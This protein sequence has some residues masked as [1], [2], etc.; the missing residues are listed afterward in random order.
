MSRLRPYSLSIVLALAAGAAFAQSL[1]EPSFPSSLSAED[2]KPWLQRNTDMDPAAVISVTPSAITGVLS[3][4]ST[5]EG[6]SIRQVNLRSESLSRGDFER[7]KVLSWTSI[8]SV[9]C[10]ARKARLGRT[11]AYAQRNLIGDG[12]ET[13]ASGAAWIKPIAG[14]PAD[15]VMRKV[16][17]GKTIN[18]FAPQPVATAA[19]PAPKARPAPVKPAA[20]PKAEAPAPPRA[21]PPVA[22]AAKP[23]PGPGPGKYVAQVMS[24]PD[25]AEARRRL[26]AVQSKASLPAGVA[27]RVVKAQVAGKTVFRV[28]FAGFRSSSDAQ[29][30]CRSSV[31]GACFARLD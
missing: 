29:A 26:R 3:S 20:S 31:S 30:F 17:D 10:K 12:R 2:L 15:R 5:P 4:I 1:N 25:E 11:M 9:D 21:A 18:A 19:A 22:A 23:A 13:M 24:S 8:I 6:P 27:G 14:G 7:D 28:Q 16:C